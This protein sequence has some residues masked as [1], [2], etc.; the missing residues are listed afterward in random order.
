M[1]R[2]FRCREGIVYSG[3][4]KHTEKSGVLLSYRHSVS[5]IKPACA[6]FGRMP[7]SAHSD[8]DK[9]GKKKNI[10]LMQHGRCLPDRHDCVARHDAVQCAGFRPDIK[11]VFL[12][13]MDSLDQGGECY[14]LWFVRGQQGR[15]EAS[16]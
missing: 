8:I 6:V 12:R 9:M 10:F 5:R 7:G 13:R 1:R 14:G 16:S 3:W 15:Q 11:R 2:A 4:P